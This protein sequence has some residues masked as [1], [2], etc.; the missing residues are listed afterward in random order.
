MKIVSFY[1]IPKYENERRVFAPSIVTVIDYL[2]DCCKEFN[3]PVE[4]ISA[5]ETR[6]VVG[7]YPYRSEMIAQGIRLTQTKSIGHRNHF[8]RCIG[9]MRSRLWLVWYLL[10]HTRAGENVF[11]GDSPV[12]YEPLILFRVF[13]RHRHIKILYFATEIYQEVIHLNPIKR[14][15]EWKLFESVEKFV[16]STEMLNKKINRDNRPY[17]ILNGVYK[18]V[19]ILGKKFDDGCKHIVYAGVINKKKGSGQAVE[20][21]N[22]LDSSYHI[23][24]L[25]FGVE[26]EIKELQRNIDFSNSVND[27]KVTY[28]GILSGESYNKF[29]QKCDVGLCSQNLNE[30]YNNSSFPSKILTYLANGLRVV[31]VDLKA[32]R[33]SGVGKLLYY[34]KSDSSKDIAAVVKQID[35]E[36]EYDSRAI[37]LELH[38]KFLKEFEELIKNR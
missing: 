17:T 27:C 4:I 2:C 1:D 10:N 15:M 20:I 25:G 28:E 19:P 7:R 29:L 38:K 14:W 36:G 22:Y 33:T 26:E 35:Y 21:A 11:F 24:I 30:K 37:L 8:L 34:S 13:S 32:I 23:H 9:K 6:N 16:V 18:P 12:L 5:A 3:E 31:S